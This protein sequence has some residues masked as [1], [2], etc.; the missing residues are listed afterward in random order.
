MGLFLNTFRI[1]FTYF[2]HTFGK[3]FEYFSHTFGIFFGKFW[4]IF[5]ILLGYFWDTFKILLG[6]IWDSLW[7]LLG[8]F[9]DT[10]YCWDT[11]GILLY[12]PNIEILNRIIRQKTLNFWKMVNH[13]NPPPLHRIKCL[14]YVFHKLNVQNFMTERNCPNISVNDAPNKSNGE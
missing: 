5:G 10:S 13:P 11:F 4:N 3:P 8:F 7:I 6:Y 14:F 12:R 1:L 2:S 9:P